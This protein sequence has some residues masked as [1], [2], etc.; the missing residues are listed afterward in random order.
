[1]IGS[2]FFHQTGVPQ[3]VARIAKNVKQVATPKSAN[4]KIELCTQTLTL[5]VVLKNI[6]DTKDFQSYESP[7]LYLRTSSGI[8][9]YGLITLMGLDIL[10]FYVM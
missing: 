2:D 1:L 10:I 6:S 5:S 3:Q 4:M 8:F 7:M 9:F